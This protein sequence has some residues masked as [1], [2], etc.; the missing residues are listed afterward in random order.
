MNLELLISL[1]SNPENEV[2]ILDCNG[3]IK[4]YCW[5]GKDKANKKRCSKCFDTWKDLAREYKI[6]QKH[7]LKMKSVKCP[8]I[9]RFKTMKE[10]I[11]YEID[12]YNVG[13]G[14]VS[15]VMTMTRDYNFDL[16]KYHE[17][18]ASGMETC[19]I[20]LKNIERLNQEY[21]FDELYIFN[22]R[23]HLN[24]GGATFAIKQNIPYVVYDRGANLNKLWCAKDNLIHDF[25]YIK[26]MIAEAW[27]KRTENAIELATKFFQDRMKGLYQS[28]DSFT[29][30]QTR[31]LL[32]F[33]FDETKENIGI[34]N[35]SIDEIFAYESWAH[36]F[37]ENDN[38]LIKN[39]LE[40][41][42]NDT[43]K[44]FYLRVHP[45]LT[46]AKELKSSQIKEINEFKAQY[47]NLTVLEPDDK[48]DTYAL[49][50]SVD[51]VLTFG[52]TVGCEATF[53]GKTSILAGKAIYEDFDCAYQANST[54]ELYQLI[55]NK[56][57]KPKPKEQAI[58]Y[59][60]YM[61]VFGDDFKFLKLE[62]ATE[63][64]IM[65][66]KFGNQYL[67]FF[68]AIFYTKDEFLKRLITLLKMELRMLI[69]LN[70]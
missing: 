15:T 4:G 24:Y 7:F 70:F 13:V 9:P 8:E 29:K 21:N 28:W 36:P 58:P 57:L 34:F 38:V 40:H 26:R 62:K 1:A 45:N 37:V 11:N 27:E 44:H 12:G 59:G 25:Y 48:I 14:P 30:N 63:E 19:Y 5:C 32:P 3:Q 68:R 55:D 2:Y 66:L 31:G 22:G 64:N 49:I 47:K 46:K 39:I 23:F 60:Y 51:K 18:V 10:A 67:N 20:T 42:K 65:K 50:K 43:S 16:E 69:D 6:P 41:Y 56:N 33:D 17:Y 35:S 54:E 52:S 61:E 53:L